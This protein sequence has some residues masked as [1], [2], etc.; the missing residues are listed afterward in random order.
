MPSIHLILCQWAR[1]FGLRSL[2]W[3]M[4]WMSEQGFPISGLQ[5][6][7]L[8]S[9]LRSKT[10]RIVV[11]RPPI[12]EPAYLYPNE[13]QAPAAMA[14]ESQSPAEQVSMFLEL[15]NCLHVSPPINPFLPLHWVSSKSSI[16]PQIS[17][18]DL[19]L[20]F[21][22]GRINTGSNIFWAGFKPSW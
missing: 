8:W 7:M 22:E 5:P 13:T 21:Q 6:G 19:R 10:H 1:S 3:E 18:K 12:S 14:S 9:L 20:S 2:V 11:S 16:R 15:L 4:K 17:Q